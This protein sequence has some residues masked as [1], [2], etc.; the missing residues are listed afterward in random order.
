MAMPP[1][2][3]PPPGV[4]PW[5]AAA[6]AAGCSC[7]L[8]LGRGAAAAAALALAAACCCAVASPP[9]A[10][11]RRGPGPQPPP[12]GDRR[13]EGRIC[14]TWGWIS[15]DRGSKATLPLTMPRRVFKSSAKDSARRPTEITLRGGGA[16]ASAGAAT[17]TAR[18]PGS[19]GGSY[20]GS[21]AGRRDGA[22]LLAGILT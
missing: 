6:W 16:G 3:G 11:G 18:A 15:V 8:G 17:P 7:C 5:A 20:C 12:A 13:G 19:R 10:R 4:K 14:A 21:A 22:P 9:R 2:P 1:L